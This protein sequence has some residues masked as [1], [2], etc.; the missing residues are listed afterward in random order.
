[1]KKSGRAEEKKKIKIRK[2]NI[3]RRFLLLFILLLMV[4]PAVLRCAETRE[5]DT[6]IQHF[7][8]ARYNFH[9]RNRAI[10]RDDRGVV[11]LANGEGVLEFD[12]LF[13]KL[14]EL[15][16]LR[17]A[18]SLAR[19]ADG[20]IY[21]GGLG[22][23]GYLEAHGMGELQYRSLKM[24]IPLLHRHFRDPVVRLE[25]TPEGLTALTDK[26]LFVFANDETRVYV[27]TGHFFTFLY[28]D[29][30]LYVVD[31]DGGLLKREGKTLAPVNGGN[32][33]RAHVILPYKQ[34]K[35]LPVT[36][37]HGPVA[38]DPATGAQT[39]FLPA[40]QT[41]GFFEE[42]LV[43]HAVQLTPDYIAL[44]SAKK[45][46]LILGPAGSPPLAIDTSTGLPDNHI[47]GMSQDAEGNLWLAREHG[48]SLIPVRWLE[49]KIKAGIL[50]GAAPPFNA[51]VRSCMFTKENFNLFAGVFYRPG[52][53]VA[54]VRQPRNLTP[55]YPHHMNHFRFLY[56]SN[57]YLH[58]QKTR[59]SSFM[60]GFDE[61]W[62]EWSER[63]YREYTNIE[64]GSY[65][66]RVRAKDFSGRISGETAYRFSITPPWH[67]SWLFL[68]F[69]M[70][71]IASI[72]FITRKIQKKGGSGKYVDVL[73]IFL[74]II[75]F[76]Y[77]MTAIGPVIGRYTDGIAFF[78]I[79]MTAVLSL[80][81]RPAQ[82]AIK[83]GI[84]RAAG[85]Q[86]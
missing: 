59:Y 48:A 76:K 46:V 80:A 14:I 53:R 22:E 65:T 85:K 39:P 58:I 41:P 61:D 15:D 36:P 30:R 62:S 12:S 37:Q 7:S 44:G 3:M 73:V 55:V 70:F 63:V 64:F 86:S 31:G 60:E 1:V 24:K 72:L 23:I 69:Q 68:M 13:W 25:M 56:S 79:I 66:F 11:Y 9:Q 77:I 18:Y 74:V 54:L 16:N 6:D 8:T 51:L 49:E 67:E 20:K 32:L 27:T 42:N 40:R 81:L 5:L 38:F 45:G 82:S 29:G 84:E 33:L 47:Y 28:W 83:K 2:E 10:V 34:N 35:L 78:K 43:T 50:P 52:T 17:S 26:R 75:I 19:G 4:L 71:F 57:N 21:V